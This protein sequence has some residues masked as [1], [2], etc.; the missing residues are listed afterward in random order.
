MVETLVV[1]PPT[2]AYTGHWPHWPLA[3]LAYTGLH[4]PLATLATLAYT[5][6][7]PHWPTLWS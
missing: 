1:R 7:W 6:H 3:T 2:L 4:W 5:G